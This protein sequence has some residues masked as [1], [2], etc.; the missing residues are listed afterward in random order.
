MTI[1][2]AQTAIAETFSCSNPSIAAVAGA[3]AYFTGIDM[4]FPA[5]QPVHWMLAG[6][7]VGPLF[8]GDG[9]TPD[10]KMAMNA[11]SGLMGGATAVFFFPALRSLP[12]LGAVVP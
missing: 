3:T 6:A 7:A 9:Y 1:A 10:R 11:F 4:L 2:E 8:C 5:A 12:V